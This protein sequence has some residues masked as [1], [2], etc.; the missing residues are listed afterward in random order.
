MQSPAYRV[1]I[2][3]I[4]RIALPVL[5][6]LY[7]LWAG[8]AAAT[9]RRYGF[10]NA[11]PDELLAGESIGQTFIARYDGLSS[12]EVHIGTYGHQ[13]D[14]ARSP[15][16][17][18]L[19][20]DPASA[21]DLA[22]ATIAP[23]QTLDIDPWYTF[24]FTP[25]AGS[26]EQHYYLLIES[27]GATTGKA[28]TLFWYQ[29]PPRADPYANGAAYRDGT[30]TKGDLAFG[31]GYDAPPLQVWTSMLGEA[32]ANTVPVLVY[33]LLLLA[34]LTTIVAISLPHLARR[35]PRLAERLGASSL[36]T[37][38]WL[39]LIYGLLF[40]VIIPPWQG[41]DEYAHF[42]YVALLDKHNLDDGAVQALDVWNTGRDTAL[43]EAINSSADRNDFTR[44]LVG[45]TAPGS[46]TR[47]DPFVFQQVRQPPTYY[48]LCALALHAASAIGID[49]D[50]YTQPEAAIY[51]MR[52]VSLVLGLLVIA[53]AWVFAWRLGATKAPLPAVLALLPMHTFIATSINNDILAELAASALFV[54]LAI[55]YK[56][57][58][59]PNTTQHGMR[60]KEVTLLVMCLV[61]TGAG[62]ATKATASAASLPLLGGGLLVWAAYKLYRRNRATPHPSTSG[63]RVRSW[64]IAL[65][66]AILAVG[67]FF[68]VCGPDDTRALGWY[69]SYT[70]VQRVERV[71]SSTAHDGAYVIQLGT[72]QTAMQ[73][74]I[75]P[76]IFHPALR[77]TVAGWARLAPEQASNA[78]GAARL[79]IMDGAREAGV[80]TTTLTSNA[81]WTRMELTAVMEQNAEQ[82]VLYIG[83][84]GEANAGV[85]FDDLSIRVEGIDRA[86]NDSIYKAALVD[87]SGENAP[88]TVRSPFANVVPADVR[89][90]AD[91]L[92][93]PQSFSKPAMWLAYANT[94]YRSFWGSFG[95]L[96]IDLPTPLYFIIAVLLLLALGSLAVR[97]LGLRARRIS[98]RAL[99]A[100]PATLAILVA[101]FAG[102][103]KQMALTAY[104]GLPSDPQGRYLFVLAIPIMWLVLS[105][106]TRLTAF[107][108][109][110][111][112]AQARY[113]AAIA[114]VLF[115]A[116]CLLALILP[117]YYGW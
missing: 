46:P 19:R 101:I 72:S 63:H 20:A 45:T 83:A 28:M 60:R 59:G 35:F 16:V 13:A 73:K 86:W 32:G 100:F 36:V 29:P 99:L 82:V 111:L 24:S 34:L 62:V 113:I 95:W 4:V 48:W 67:A 105:G 44:R 52:L 98:W 42:A 49:A 81:N 66:A 94:Q 104:G 109:A 70:P 71:A 2:S 27:P 87:P 33:A 38:L 114:I 61:L 102:F 23:A 31:L 12:V 47:T 65:I 6:A 89:D 93:N 74:L 40:V 15:L 84:V 90:M 8:Y 116:Y 106:L 85:Q 1:R 10:A 58:F 11:V 25:I 112:N 110:W 75:P 80:I 18:H 76:L 39:A 57:S 88:W 3:L 92:L 56:S 7:V 17:L 108:P 68:V 96:S 69:T 64:A 78:A 97:A 50:P 14:A 37:A 53:L 54:T 79:S 21:V 26:R 30:I 107:L 115:A 51:I 55:L 43:I 41:P 91:A 9:Q 117:Y 5:A 103:A 77:I 22:T